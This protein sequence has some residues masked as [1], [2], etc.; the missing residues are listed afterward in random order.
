MNGKLEVCADYRR[1]N[2]RRTSSL[3]LPMSKNVSFG[4]TL[5]NAFKSST[6]YTSTM[7]A[8]GLLDGVRD[9]SPANLF[10][11]LA[12]YRCCCGFCRLRVGLLAI[13]LFCL[14]YP[15]IVFTALYFY[16]HLLNSIQRS[17]VTLPLYVFLGYQMV[18][19]FLTLIGL[20]LDLY[21]WLIPLQ[22]SL[23]SNIIMAIG[24]GILLMASTDR[25]NTHLFPAFAITSMILV[26]LYLWCLVITCMTF[27]LIRDKR[28]LSDS[29][30]D[31]YRNETMI[32][33]TNVPLIERVNSAQF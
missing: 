13:A 18:A 12:R 1:N 32:I 4:G 17:Y 31:I 22:L 20:F 9:D 2:L 25:T 19:A 7:S 30:L 28:R 6:I 16:G 10:V 29:E 8:A 3:Q 24:L 15:P 23:T 33:A 21:Y 5:M 14:T 11:S 27:V 26:G